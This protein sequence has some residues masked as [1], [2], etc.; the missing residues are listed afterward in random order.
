MTVDTT[1]TEIRGYKE[2]S[3]NL[4]YKKSTYAIFNEE[5]QLWDYFKIKL[6]EA[7]GLF[8]K[9]DMTPV[10]LKEGFLSYNRKFYKSDFDT[11]IKRKVY[12]GHPSIIPAAR[13]TNTSESTSGDNAGRSSSLRGNNTDQSGSVSSHWLEECSA[14]NMA[15]EEQIRTLH[16]L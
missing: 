2:S 13:T 9:L 1:V 11:L 3:Q 10:L 4:V 16:L 14:A 15:W 6:G 7:K 8:I 5:T 12:I